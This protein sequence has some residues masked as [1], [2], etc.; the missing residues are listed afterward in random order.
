[1]AIAALGAW[2][3]QLQGQVSDL[4]DQVTAS[5]TYQTA[6]ASVLEVAFREGSQ[7]A[8]MQPQQG[9]GP[10]GIAAVSPDGSIQ[11][12]LQD[13]A[14]TSGN[15]VYETWAIVGDDAPVPLGS[16]TV[17]A[18]GTASFTSRAGPAVPGV[19]VAVSREPAAGATAPTEVVSVG[20]AVP[21]SS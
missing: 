19:V 14:P 11:F 17:G 2:N 7:T 10:R 3:F 5:R 12:A 13:L 16:F 21:P 18:S 6:I 15:Q 20:A 9:G 1:M 8:I 4:R